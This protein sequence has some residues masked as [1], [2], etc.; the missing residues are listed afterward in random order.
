MTDRKP[1]LDQWVYEDSQT[2]CNTHRQ[3]LKRRLR[4]HTAIVLAS[5]IPPAILN[6]TK[7]ELAALAVFAEA[8]PG[9]LEDPYQKSRCPG[10]VDRG[11]DEHPDCPGHTALDDAMDAALAAAKGKA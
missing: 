2:L 11:P 6:A 3:T 9:L 4:G 1:A 7:E 10:C 5:D 8:M